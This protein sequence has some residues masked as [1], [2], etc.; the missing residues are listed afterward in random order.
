VIK[1]IFKFFSRRNPCWRKCGSKGWVLLRRETVSAQP[2][3][4]ECRP[5]IFF[6]VDDR[7]RCRACGRV[8]RFTGDLIV[9]IQ[10][11]TQQ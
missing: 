11:P 9:S 1:K 10:K 2:G 7:V 3:V 5:V 8:H 4:L 6:T